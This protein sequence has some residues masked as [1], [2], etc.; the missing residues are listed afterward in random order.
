M[1]NKEI[2]KIEKLIYHIEINTKNWR[3]HIAIL[4]STMQ[5]A[6]DTVNH[7]QQTKAIIWEVLEISCYSFI[8]EVY[9]IQ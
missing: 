9:I 1:I 4:A 8:R 5:E 7:M 6:I 2:K 3:E